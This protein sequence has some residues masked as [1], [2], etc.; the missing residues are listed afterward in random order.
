MSSVISPSTGSLSTT[1]KRLRYQWS[2]RQLFADLFAKS[3]MMGPAV[4][5]SALSGSNNA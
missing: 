3:W 1:M 2:P 5:P 4:P